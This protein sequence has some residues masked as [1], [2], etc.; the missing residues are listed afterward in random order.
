M[1]SGEPS[2]RRSLVLETTDFHEAAFAWALGGRLTSVRG[3]RPGT[4]CVEIDA[5]TTEQIDVAVDALIRELKE[6]KDRG[7]TPRSLRALAD[8]T[9]LSR[10]FSR[11]GQIKNRAHANARQRTERR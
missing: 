7:V 11:Y 9:I 10:I 5:I 3:S 2:S 4:A 6:L 8:N 1:S